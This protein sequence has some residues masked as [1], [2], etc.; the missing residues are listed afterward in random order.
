MR[1]LEL[2]DD[3]IRTIVD[4]GSL[5]QAGILKTVS[6]DLKRVVEES[7]HNT[8]LPVKPPDYIVRRTGKYQEKYEYLDFVAGSGGAVFHMFSLR[9]LVTLRNLLLTYVPGRIMREIRFLRDNMDWC[10]PHIAAMLEYA[11]CLDDGYM[12]ETIMNKVD[13]ITDDEDAMYGRGAFDSLVL[14]LY[15]V[16]GKDDTRREIQDGIARDRQLLERLRCLQ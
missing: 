4:C 1:F 10:E 6:R 9:E 15:D 13:D 3:V 7:K 12:I 8:H 14:A 11:K 2:P 16:Y 5:K